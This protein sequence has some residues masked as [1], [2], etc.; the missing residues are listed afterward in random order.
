LSDQKLALL[1]KEAKGLLTRVGNEYLQHF[2]LPIIDPSSMAISK[3]I[4][5]KGMGPHVDTPQE[6]NKLALITA[7][8]YLNENYEGGE[9]LFKN[10]GVNIKPSA[11]SIVIFPS[12]D[13]FFHESLNLK[14]GNK[15][16]MPL[17]WVKDYD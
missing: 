11:G 12:V 4:P 3:Y 2:G 14:S 9:L 10:Q 16:I 5:G 15:Y 1:I 7:I 17:F 8:L 13:P 6:E